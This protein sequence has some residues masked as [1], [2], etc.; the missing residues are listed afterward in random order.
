MSDDKGVTEEDF[1][2]QQR[3][4]EELKEALEE[5]TRRMHEQRR[6]YEEAKAHADNS[7]A[8]NITRSEG[9]AERCEVGA[10]QLKLA[11]FQ[12]KYVREW[13]TSIEASFAKAHIKKE[14]TKYNHAIAALPLEAQAKIADFINGKPPPLSQATPY[15]RFKEELLEKYEKTT[16]E[17]LD[18]LFNGMALGDR[19][20]SELL[21][22]MRREAGEEVSDKYLEPL[23]LSRLPDQVRAVVSAIDVKLKEKGKAADSILDK[24]TFRGGGAATAVVNTQQVP[25]SHGTTADDRMQLMEM[26]VAAVSKGF[27][28]LERHRSRERGNNYG[29]RNRSAS[30]PRR[31]P[32]VCFYHERFGQQAWQ[33]QGNCRFS[34]NEKN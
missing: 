28:T 30:R 34:K 1:R 14:E 33:C 10:A 3:A 24:V 29:R 31:D 25:T 12:A 11:T 23:W 9:E 17:K 19:K 13:F 7:P 15:T 2:K 32:S 21:A 6:L 5:E 16:A 8:A 26:I 27:E 22:Q 18:D 20:P 4:I